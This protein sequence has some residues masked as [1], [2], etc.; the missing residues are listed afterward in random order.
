MGVANLI[1]RGPFVC[2]VV[3]VST[4]QNPD[5]L[6]SG[7]FFV[8]CNTSKFAILKLIQIE[9]LGKHLMKYECFK[10]LSKI[11]TDKH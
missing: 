11:R 4:T 10:V 3:N 1:G 9:I 8:N 2:C 5:F 6:L 7:N